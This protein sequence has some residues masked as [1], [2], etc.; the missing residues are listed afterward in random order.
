MSRTLRSPRHQALTALLVDERR[1]A[2]LTQAQVAAKLGRYQS[3]VASIESGQRRVDVVE[4]LDFAEV[5]GF[6]PRGAIK[7]LLLSKRR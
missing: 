1:K 5:I 7:K 6:D 4:F 3:F 2:G